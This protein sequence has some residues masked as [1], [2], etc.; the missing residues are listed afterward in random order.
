MAFDA[1]ELAVVA[2]TTIYE[3]HEQNKERQQE[4]DAMNNAPK[5]PG[6]NPQPDESQLGTQS[7]SRAV[8][9]NGRVS[10]LAAPPGGPGSSASSTSAGLSPSAMYPSMGAAPRS[11]LGG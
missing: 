6:Q 7:N 8:S 1:I 3:A 10:P 4:E 11:I 5:M 9:A 2:G